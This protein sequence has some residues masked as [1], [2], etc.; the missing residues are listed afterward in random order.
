MAQTAC[1]KCDG[2]GWKPVETQGVRRL[3]RC[4]CFTR[5]RSGRVLRAARIPKRYE[6]CSLENFEHTRRY[7]KLGQ[8]KLVARRYTEE[9]P[10]EYG[11][12]FVGPSGRG[13]THLA[14]SVLRK[15]IETKGVEGRFYDFHHL[16]QEIQGTYDSLSQSSKS[17]VLQPVLDVEVLLLDELTA[18]RPTDWMRETLAY[19]INS[20]YNDKKVTLITTTLS[21][22]KGRKTHR[23]PSGEVLP[24]LESSL[25]QLGDTLSSRLYEMCRVVEME[26]VDF[27]STFKQASYDQDWVKRPE[28]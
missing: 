12:L 2:T 28:S 6:H 23:A 4:D 19:V 27:R 14:V 22:R 18:P 7:K 24:D 21:P 10:L 5:E 13:K 16:L 3:T 15:L 8:A 9:Y 26:G 1:S 25:V 20:R 11:L 17:A